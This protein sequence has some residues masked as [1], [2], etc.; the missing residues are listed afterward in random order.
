MHSGSGS[1]SGSGFGIIMLTANE[2]PITTLKN[3]MKQRLI[4]LEYATSD[5][6]KQSTQHTEPDG[7]SSDITKEIEVKIAGLI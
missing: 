3:T 5:K 7:I 2:Q 1:G 6:F 4:E